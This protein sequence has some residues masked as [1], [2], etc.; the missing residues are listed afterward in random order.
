[1]SS[2][3]KVKFRYFQKYLDYNPLKLSLQTNFV[4]LYRSTLLNSVGSWNPLK[5]WNPE[6]KYINWNIKILTVYFQQPIKLKN[7][8]HWTTVKKLVPRIQLFCFFTIVSYILSSAKFKIK[9]FYIS[10][11][12]KTN[13]FCTNLFSNYG[14]NMIVLDLSHLL[15]ASYEVI[16][17][18]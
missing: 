16:I 14:D 17:K 15:N 7:C 8:W 1:M 18:Y 6:D 3:D 11:F 5:P 2:I 4:N 12:D 9:I 10:Y 13:W